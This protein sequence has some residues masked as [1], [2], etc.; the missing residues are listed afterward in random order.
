M[1][2]KHL[3]QTYLRLVWIN[4]LLIRTIYLWKADL[5]GTGSRSEVLC[6]Y[7]DVATLSEKFYSKL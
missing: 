2:L 3:I 6:N 5:S 7:D 1:L 4:F